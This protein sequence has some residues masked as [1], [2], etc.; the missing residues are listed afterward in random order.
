M[1]AITG[2]TYPVK[3]QIRALG[4]QWD[5]DK[6]VWLVPA[7]REQQARKLVASAPKHTDR[8]AMAVRKRGGIP[9]TCSMCG[10]QCKYPYDECWDCKE[11]REMGY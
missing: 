11:E 4:G 2:N 5:K 8:I 3:D 6:K 9:G 7:D 10:G 1:T